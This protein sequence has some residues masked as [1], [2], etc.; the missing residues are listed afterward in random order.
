MNRGGWRR[1]RKQELG[2]RFPEFTFP[3][4]IDHICKKYPW[5]LRNIKMIPWREPR[6]LSTVLG[7]VSMRAA[8]MTLRREHSDNPGSYKADDSQKRLAVV[9]GGSLL[10]ILPK[11]WRSKDQQMA[12]MGGV[13]RAM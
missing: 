2:Y 5:A 12:E 1:A 13:V 6:L 9:I 4:F 8:R 7:T 11:V 10:T 3:A